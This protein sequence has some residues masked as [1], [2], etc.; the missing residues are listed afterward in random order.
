MISEALQTESK[1]SSLTPGAPG[2]TPGGPG[3]TPGGP[4]VTQQSSDTK[5]DVIM[6]DAE[7][8]RNPAESSDS[9]FSEQAVRYTSASQVRQKPKRRTPK[10][11]LFTFLSDSDE[12]DD[13]VV[14]ILFVL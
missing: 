1:A 5:N 3:V 4:A 6:T 2:A 9:E 10:A 13:Y 14:S 7:P 11:N 8:V 12:D